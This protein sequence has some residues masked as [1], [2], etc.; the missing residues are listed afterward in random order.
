MVLVADIGGTKAVL[1]IAS[2]KNGRITLSSRKRYPVASHGSLDSVFDA[3]LE[4]YPEVKP[5]IL[6]VA[7]AGPVDGTFCR[8]TNI[9]WEIDGKALASKYRL[10]RVH[11]MNDLMASGYGLDFVEADKVIMIHQG[12]GV[13]AGNR[14]VISPG[15][16]LG[17]AIIHYIDKRHVPIASE[18]GLVDFAPFD[19]MTYRLSEFLRRGRSRVT[20]EDTLSGPGIYNIFTFIVSESGTELTP[21]AERALATD[22]GA[23]VTGWALDGSDCRAV[24]TLALF[25][26]ILASEAGNMALKC[27]ARGGVFIGGGIVPRILP[28][29]DQTRFAKHFADKEPHTDLLRS[30][31][32]MAVTDTDLPLYG[33]AAYAFLN[34]A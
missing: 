2:E 26:D 27:L 22:P 12:E 30:I 31:P 34:T 16:G 17:E 20:E 7:A 18:G 9:D 23:V 33:A 19:G 13:R 15:T 4:Q 25:L 21:E 8:M 14:L 5:E 6:S 1:A 10:K 29:I 11:L 3:Y 24:Q 32:V 28:L